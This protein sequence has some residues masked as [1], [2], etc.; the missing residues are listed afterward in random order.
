MI[1]NG[2]LFRVGYKETDVHKRFK[3]LGLLLLNKNLYLESN[4]EKLNIK[5]VQG[6]F[7]SREFSNRD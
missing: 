2:D 7:F 6:M 1:N 4:Y 5:N 3:N